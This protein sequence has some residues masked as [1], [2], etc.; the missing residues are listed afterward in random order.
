MRT[1]RTALSG[2]LVA[3]LLLAAG[4]ALAA[5][6]PDSQPGAVAPSDAARAKVEAAREAVKAARSFGATTIVDGDWSDHG[7]AKV[8]GRVNFAALRADAGGWMIR[9]FGDAKGEH[10]VSVDIAFDGVTA[11]STARADKTI[12]EM[13]PANADE[14]RGFFVSQRAAA[15]VPWDLL[16]GF[17]FPEGAAFR[18]AGRET[19]AGADC[20]LVS[21]AIPDNPTVLTIA[22]GVEDHL[23]RRFEWRTGGKARSLTLTELRPNRPLSPSNFVVSAPSDFTVKPIPSPSRQAKIDEARKP[24][25]APAKPETPQA[26]AKPGEVALGKPAPAFALK[27]P[28]GETVSLEGLKGS[29]VLIDFWATWCGPCK[30]A[31]PSLQEFHKDYESKGLKV[32]GINAW[33]RGDAVKYKKDQGYTYGL[34]LN[35]DETAKAYG[36]SGIPAFFLI[37]RDGN[38][39]WKGVGW[40][41][42]AKDNMKNAI[43]A[44]LAPPGAD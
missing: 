30:A 1:N 43:E 9:A 21:I 20:D 5:S 11:R 40:S 26:P 44:A 29:V 8:G 39:A 10:A 18:T 3:S 36:V 33:E 38:L 37:D 25:A 32:I 23:P 12:F 2:A 14:T 41:P 24:A 27:N 16:A 34:L 19:V 13:N 35:G 17:T 31:M 6:P 4:H 28:E 15:S 42:T 22:F 7:G